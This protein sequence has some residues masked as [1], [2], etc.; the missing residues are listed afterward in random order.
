M[1]TLFLLPMEKTIKP[2][3]TIGSVFRLAN[4]Y[5]E[6]LDKNMSTFQFCVSMDIL[7][8]MNILKSFK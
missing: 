2:V 1:E 7:D 6:C 8:Y 4:I 5:L 3:F